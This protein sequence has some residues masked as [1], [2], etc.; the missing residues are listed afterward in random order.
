MS[1]AND[2][3]IDPP[4]FQVLV[5]SL[6]RASAEEIEAIILNTF[7]N[8]IA[9]QLNGYSPDYAYLQRNWGKV[10]EATNSQMKKILIVRRLQISPNHR[11]IS[12]FAEIMTS[13]GYCVRQSSEFGACPRCHLAIPF[14]ALWARL[15]ERGCAVPDRWSASCQG[16]QA[17]EK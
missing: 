13:A 15:K 10:A 5:D 3:F 1:S 6:N 14:E 9:M 17:Q 4:N 2:S 16:C 8:W 11:L 7:P 12:M